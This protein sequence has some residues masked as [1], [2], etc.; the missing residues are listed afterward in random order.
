VVVPEETPETPGMPTPHPELRKLDR[1]VGCWSMEGHVVGSDENNIRGK[2]SYRWLPGG[3]FM[4]QHVT[5][6]FMGTQID[7]TELIGY[8]PQARGFKSTVYSN[9]SPVPLPYSWDVQGDTVTISVSYGPLDATFTGKFSDD[10]QEFSGGW[11][12]NP[13]ADQTV[14]VPYDVGGRRL[15]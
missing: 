11:R 3:F 6:D 9:L 5:L 15:S 8:D 2:T 10:G 12:P 7:S 13:G 4:E 1:F 14:N